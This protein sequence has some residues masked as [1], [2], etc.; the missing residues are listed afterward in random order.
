M[1][2][3]SSAENILKE[4]TQDLLKLMSVNSPVEVK[5]DSANDA[6]VVTI[7]GG[8]ETGL[9][10]GRKGDTLSSIQTILGILFKQKSGEWRRVVVNVGDYRE[11]EE[12]YLKNLARTTAE[13][14]KDTGNPQS[15]YNLTPAQ[16]RIIH[17]YLSEDS[18]IVTESQGEGLERYLVVKTK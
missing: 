5:F 1:K 2:D 6:F 4:L 17:L 16:R 9:L 10:I 11:K 7:Q 18:S 8:S 3:N 15:L 14:A 13:R 12:D